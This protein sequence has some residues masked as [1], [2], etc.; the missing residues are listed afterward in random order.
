MER[1]LTSQRSRKRAGIIRG[2]TATD[3]REIA[4][5]LAEVPEASRWTEGTLAGFLASGYDPW[6]AVSEACVVGL[7]IGRR[8]A[9]EFELL[10]LAVSPAYRRRGIAAALLDFA[11][12]EACKAGVRKVFLE[13][14]AGNDAAIAFYRALGFSESGLRKAYYQNPA[15]DALLFSRT[16]PLDGFC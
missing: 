1:G 4:E 3:L 5:L 16:L 2:M 11:F 14:R 6:I 13:V 15:E 9:D 12:R 8:A 10:N 7:V